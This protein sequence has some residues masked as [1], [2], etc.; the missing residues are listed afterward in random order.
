MSDIE[1]KG[2]VSI[3]T[4]DSASKIDGVKRSLKEAGDESK[5]STGHFS[6]LKESLSQMPGPAK[7][8]TESLHGIRGALDILKAHPIIGIFVLI[9][10]LVVA[11]FK[12]FSEMKDV[13]ESL[14]KAWGALSGIFDVFM[15]KILKPLI[16]GF[17]TLI[18]WVTKAATWITSLFS[19][20][21]ASAGE[22]IGEHTE[23]LQK[24]KRAEED[25]NIE[26]AHS[27]AKLKEL[28]EKAADAN[29]PIRERIAALKEGAIVEKQTLDDAIKNHTQQIR[30]LGAIM[31][32]KMGYTE[33]DAAAI[34]KAG[35]AELEMM[36][37]VAKAQKNVNEAQVKEISE[38]IIATEALEKQSATIGKRVDSQ[39]RSLGKEQAAKAKE[40]AKEKEAERK[41]ELANLRAF[42]D[43]ELKLRQ[44]IELGAIQDTKEK[45]LR[46]INNAY[47]AEAAA[48]QKAFNEK[49]LSED[50]F[51]TLRQEALDLFFQKSAAIEKKYA[52]AKAE[53]AKKEAKEKAD[54]DK[55]RAEED[56]KAENALALRKIDFQ[57]SLATKDLKAQKKWLD[58]KQAEIERQ[59]KLEIEAAKNNAVKLAEIEQKHTEDT[60]ANIAARK[61]LVWAEV[62]EKVQAADA[63]G[64]TLDNV[65]NLVGKATGVGKVLAI[66]AGTISAITSG[67][68][69]Y[70]SSLEIPVVGLALAPINAAIAIAAGMA[71]VAKIKAVKVPGGDSGSVP[72]IPA[73]ITPQLQT[74]RTRLD[75]TSIQAVGNAAA[76]GV[77]RAFVL[78]SD[79]HNN[80]ERED[81]LNRAAR[82]G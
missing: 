28:Q 54:N 16:D 12:R 24:L 59:Y 39:L 64:S 9:A 31:A 56:L 67:I 77:N 46:I 23:N 78:A 53:K 27:L 76:G 65:A 52:D 7:A 55:K 2:K 75:S 43:K 32:L 4:G 34:Q 66:A 73:P 42:E 5:A 8:A 80:T 61:A 18:G 48:N 13:S 35:L 63:I 1:I 44:E 20:A 74:S 37:K 57:L 30:E 11:L 6:N 68:K 62:N 26:R 36:L 60:D 14:G 41:A 45:E 70:Q 82:L 40:A 81:M 71:N 19:P 10:G 29:I 72:S 79:I 17:V 51:F 47:Q 3:D 21:I 69:A 15:D 49:K 33:A 50:Q 38:L 25:S 22:A 58:A